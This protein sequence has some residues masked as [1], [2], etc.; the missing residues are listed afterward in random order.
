MQ[1]VSRTD[2]SKL[3]LYGKDVQVQGVAEARRR[4]GSI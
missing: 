1:L 4:G 3:D 2:R